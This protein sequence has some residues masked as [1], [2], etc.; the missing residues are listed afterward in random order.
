M[1]YFEGGLMLIFIG[2]GLFICPHYLALSQRSY[3]LEQIDMSYYEGQYT[4]HELQDY[5]MILSELSSIIPDLY[6]TTL[7][8]L[9][10]LHTEPQKIIHLGTGQLTFSRQ[11]CTHTSHTL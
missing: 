2:L 1:G 5:L 9:N 6:N 3:Q 8:Q 7:K 11:L 10:R 4:Q